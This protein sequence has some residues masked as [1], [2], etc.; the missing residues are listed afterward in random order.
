MTCLLIGLQIL[1]AVIRACQYVC[2]ITN[3]VPTF[4]CCHD[5]A[6]TLL[7][8]IYRK[9]SLGMN[10]QCWEGNVKEISIR[11]KGRCHACWS[12]GTGWQ[13]SYEIL[14]DNWCFMSVL[15]V[16]YM[17]RRSYMTYL[18]TAVGLT[19]GGSTHLH[20]NNTQNNTNNNRTKQ[21]NN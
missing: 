3:H 19:P 11:N 1:S 14:T 20:T 9:E 5:S 18:L 21:N 8:P 4:L 16:F 13:K 15:F 7:I 2:E 17:F 6:R 12:G 10:R